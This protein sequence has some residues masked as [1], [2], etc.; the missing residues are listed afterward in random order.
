MLH[1]SVDALCVKPNGVYADATFGGG[2]HARAILA[3]LK[4]G[5]LIAFDRDGDAGANRI[6][7]KRFLLVQNN[8]RFLRAL[9]RNEGITEVDGVL[10][11]LGVSSH[12]FDTGERGFS[13]RFEAPLDMRMDRGGALT[14][15]QVVNGYSEAQLCSLLR[16]YGEVEHAAHAAKLLVAARERKAITTIG[17]LKEA[18]A[19]CTP[20]VMEH[21]Y[22]AKVFQALRI[23]VNGEMK[24][25]EQLLAQAL[26]VLKPGGR[27]VVI[28]YHSLEDRVVKN[29]MRA[30]N[31]EGKIEKDMFGKETTPFTVITKKA[32]VP[33]ENE[34]RQNTRARSA[35]LRVAEKK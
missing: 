3:R 33:D 35:K 34:I 24:A 5:R 22:L 28:T 11:D 30:G 18:L 13:F 26:K 7:D 9:L 14:A 10:A 21:K 8:F 25:L 15:A 20:S 4:N 19:P 2:G 6:A 27:L 12:Q 23:A 16:T 17:D 1:Q 29:F 32:V 31:T